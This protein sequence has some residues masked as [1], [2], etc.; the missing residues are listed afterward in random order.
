MTLDW[1]THGAALGC[2]GAR[3]SQRG[4][5]QANR[6][7]AHAEP[8]VVHELEH[9][10]KALT[11]LAYELRRR[12]VEGQRDRRR[13]VMSEFFLHAI[14]GHESRAATVG[15]VPVG[16]NEEQRQAVEPALRIIRARAVLRARDDEVVLAVPGGNE[17]LLPAHE[18][19]APRVLFADRAQ[20]G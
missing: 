16:G 20:S 7:E 5:A 2:I 18:P 9:V 6:L 4:F 1:L 15:F 8:R 14:D 3:H 17:N 12:A 10:A 19:V 13:A 11:P